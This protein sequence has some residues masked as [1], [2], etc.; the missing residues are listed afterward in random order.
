MGNTGPNDTAA[1]LGEIIHIL[2]G[3]SKLEIKERNVDGH[4]DNWFKYIRNL[5]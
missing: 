4:M 1:H 5:S 2:A 3:C